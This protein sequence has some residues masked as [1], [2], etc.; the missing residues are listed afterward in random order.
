MPTDLKKV[1]GHSEEKATRAEF[2]KLVDALETKSVLVAPTEIR[3]FYDKIELSQALQRA[4]ISFHEA[5][6]GR[7]GL[8]IQSSRYP[9]HWTRIKA[10]SRR[11]ARLGKNEYDSLKPVADLIR[12]LSEQIKAF[13]VRPQK[14]E[15]A[16][17]SEE[18]QQVTIDSIASN[19]YTQ[20][21]ALA[22]KRLIRD[23]LL[24]WETAYTRWGK[25]S[26]KERAYDLEMI[27]NLAVPAG[28]F[29]DDNAYKFTMSIVELVRA[30]VQAKGGDLW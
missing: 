30:S 8:T 22:Q 9:E 14:W 6:R 1:C 23:H 3:L 5:W 4:V 28:K 2:N 16:D 17:S 20:L 18:M 15:P 25:G 24:K 21:H 26:A 11:P 10:L 13:L 19:I 7:L 27:Y 29:I 12:E